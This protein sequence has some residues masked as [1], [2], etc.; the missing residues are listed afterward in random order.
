M[1]GLSDNEGLMTFPFGHART[2]AVTDPLTELERCIDRLHQRRPRVW[3]IVITVFGDAVRPRGG[4]VWLST[5]STLLERLRVNPGTLGAALS[6]LTAE[7]WLEREKIGRRSRYRLGAAGKQA[8]DSASRR[9][10]G[11]PEPDWTG[12]WCFHTVADSSP[13]DLNEARNLDFGQLG[14]LT[15]VRA[16]RED[17]APAP[18]WLANGAVAIANT[19]CPDT[20]VAAAFDLEAVETRYADFTL[21]FAPLRRSLCDRT[22]PPLEAL[23][24]RTLLLHAFRRVVLREPGVPPAALPRTPGRQE[25]RALMSTTYRALLPASEQWLDDRARTEEESWGPAAPSL[26]RRFSTPPA[27][28]P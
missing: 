6:R 21:G 24:A 15:F 26:M 27:R 5:L 2:R 14:P 22:L 10:Y 17:L 1:S 20:L 28:E 8:F 19:T 9:I 16:E 12:R 13:R 18:D 23:A 7:G 25:A 11:F 4:E 3:S